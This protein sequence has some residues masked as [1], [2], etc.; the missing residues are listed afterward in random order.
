MPTEPMI[1][2]TCHCGRVHIGVPHAPETVNECTCSICRRY[3]T[4]WAYYSPK[5]VEVPPSA[6]AADIYMWGD[7]LLEFHRCKD[8]GCITHWT[9]ID[10]SFDRMGVNARLLEPVVLAGARRLVNNGRDR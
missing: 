3:G 2:A 6:G 9:H 10:K 7:R 8:C 4:L 1:E 5:R